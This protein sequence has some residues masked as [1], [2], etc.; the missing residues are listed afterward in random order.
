MSLSYCLNSYKASPSSF[1]FPKVPEEA[2]VYEYPSCLDTWHSDRLVGDAKLKI[3]IHEFDKLNA[4][5]GPIKKV[6]LIVVGF[7]D[8]D[9]NLGKLQEAKWVGG[10]QND[11]VIC[12]GYAPLEGGVPNICWTYCFSWCE[13][14][15]MK[16]NIEKMFYEGPIDNSILPKLKSE[17]TM[18]YTKREWDEFDSLRVKPRLKH[19]K[20]LFIVMLLTQGALYLFFVKNGYDRDGY[21]PYRYIA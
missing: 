11:V 14:D 21:S 3:D 2:P 4:I 10:K 16:R 18:N 17:I 12:Y 9:A 6:N 19:Y 1:S 20:I 5:L 15:Q 13:N 7:E 8:A